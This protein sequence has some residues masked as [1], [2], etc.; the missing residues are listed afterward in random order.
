MEK[1]RGYKT[2]GR[3]DREGR[4]A[5]KNKVGRG[6]TFRDVREFI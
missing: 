6:R 2:S 1:F 3:K 5:L 4:L